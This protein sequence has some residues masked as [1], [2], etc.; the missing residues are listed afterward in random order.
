VLPALT[1]ITYDGMDIQDGQTA[2][3]EYL[4]VT[5]TQVSEEEKKKVF[6]ALEEYCRQDT[7]AMVEVLR[8]LDSILS[9]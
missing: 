2:S 4:R 8:V 7:L 5:Q 6:A 9:I 3:N 1:G